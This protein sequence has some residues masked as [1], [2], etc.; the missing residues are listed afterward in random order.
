M[1]KIPSGGGKKALKALQKDGWEI[2][3]Q[4]GSHV[5]LTKTG[6]PHFIIVPLHGG[7]SIPTGTL[8]NIIKDAGL[9]VE[10]FIDLL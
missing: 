6:K 9:T 3:S 5:K 7:A 8:S 2:K 4:K 10:A 1:T